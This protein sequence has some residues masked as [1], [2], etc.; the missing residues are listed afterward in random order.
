MIQIGKSLERFM[1]CNIGEKG[2]AFRM[3]LGII[4]ILG[5]ILLSILTL[6]EV[7]GVGI[8]WF[9][10]ISMFLGG[11]FSIFESL[12]GWCIVRAMGIKT[13]L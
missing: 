8:G 2:R 13:P 1:Q 5:G 6:T 4:I 10:S 12:K 11:A 9:A 7:I 3:K